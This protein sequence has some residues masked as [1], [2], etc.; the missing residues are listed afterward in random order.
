MFEVIAPSIAFRVETTGCCSRV[1]PQR[2][3]AECAHRHHRCIEY[4]CVR[5]TGRRAHDCPPHLPEL[6][7][8]L[9]GCPSPTLRVSITR[10]GRP[11]TAIAHPVPAQQSSRQCRPPVGCC[12][13]DR[14][15]CNRHYRLAQWRHW[16][17]LFPSELFR[18][19]TSGC[20]PPVG[21]TVSSPV[22]HPGRAPR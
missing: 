16:P 10:Q 5:V 13:W 3:I 2:Q 20:D 7:V 17:G 6:N 15:R 18:V 22:T 19:E 11:D 21:H 4:V 14:P 12:W 1:G 9:N 8:P